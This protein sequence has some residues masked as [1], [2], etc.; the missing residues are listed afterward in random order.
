M[1]RLQ[2][3]IVR[4]AH[5][6]TNVPSTHQRKF[7]NTPHHRF[8]IPLHYEKNYAYPLLIWLHGPTGGEHEINQV[9]P[10]ISVRNYVGVSPR[11]VT[12]H[13]RRHTNGDPTFTWDQQARSIDKAFNDVSRCMAIAKQRFNI[14]SNRVFLVG[15]GTG[16][17][18][19]LRLAL[20]TPELFAGVVSLGGGIP[21]TQQ[22]LVSLQR[23]RSLPVMMMHCRD[24]VEYDTQQ[25]C[26]DLR[27]LHS[28]GLNVSMFQYPCE[29][30]VTTKM[31]SDLNSW[32]MER[33]AG[34]TETGSK[35]DDPT[36]MRIR[37]CN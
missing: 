23:A 20:Q 32:V 8:F 27:L 34:T 35:F 33:V 26:D 24:S 9:M 2:I 31:L 30:E 29:Q 1:N 14:A 22:P 3:G 37:D 12:R 28:A 10:H 7:Q 16:G 6:R 4:N 17:T 13:A 21:R 5:N 19:A 36:R 25:A 11:G 18:M 15:N